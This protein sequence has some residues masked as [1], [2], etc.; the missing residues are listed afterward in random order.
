VTATVMIASAPGKVLWAGE[1]AVLDGHPAVVSAVDRR[2][3]ARFGD[4]AQELSPFLEA[5]R[6]ELGDAVGRVQV[7]SSA[8]A[9]DGRK[10]GLGSS[11]A[12]VVAAAGLVLGTD[13]RARIHEVAHRA[14]A[15]AQAPRGARGSGAD[16]A[17]SV[18]GGLLEV[19]RTDDETPN[20]V[21]RIAGA[22]P[23]F[24]LVWTET[25]ADTPTLVA[26]VRAFAASAPQAHKTCM[27]H[28]GAVAA[29]LAAAMRAAD[30]PGAV[31][32]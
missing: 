13:D 31:A 27:D 12:A 3:V 2:V 16:I 24:C 26:R 17:A 8:L 1:Y 22:P 20:L 32:A 28:L 21:E 14:H 10:L 5:V 25:P 6:A 15:R 18:H 9:R 7:D 19:T 11:A 23:P 30:A 29:G 4:A